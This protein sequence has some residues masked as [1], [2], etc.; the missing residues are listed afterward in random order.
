MS[1]QVLFFSL[2]LVASTAHLVGLAR[3]SRGWE[4]STKPLLM[5][6]LAAYLVSDAASG[7]VPL[8]GFILAGVGFGFLG[9][10]FLLGQG[11][12]WSFL[13]GLTA[14]LIGHLLYL[15]AFLPAILSHRF[16]PLLL[17]AL[18]PFVL[19]GLWYLRFLKEGLAELLPA[20]AAYTAIIVAMT[21][22]ALLRA[23]ALGH[24]GWI[25]FAGAVSFMLSDSMLGIAV[26]RNRTRW[27]DVAIMASYL[28]G[29]FLIVYGMLA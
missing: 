19:F 23:G 29:Q 24:A 26:F 12:Q 8:P 9:D 20:V 14:F 2:Y 1:L 4:T 7:G 13:V 25:V 6:L 10:L 27:L 22:A 3:A 16:E 15:I 28:L 17:L 21:T 5:P 11:R 18:I